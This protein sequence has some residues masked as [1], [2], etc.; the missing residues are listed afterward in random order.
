MYKILSINPG[1][2]STKLGYFEDDE[3]IIIKNIHHNSEELLK[4]DKV[5]DQLDFRTEEVEKFL[6]ENNI[7]INE[8]DGVG[9]RGGVLPRHTTGTFEVTDKICEFSTNSPLQ[10]PVNLAVLIAKKIADKAGV[11]AYI[12]DGESSLEMLPENMLSGLPELPRKN[13]CHVLNQKAIAR[14]HA[15]TTGADYFKSN[16]IV[17]H[18][19][20]G[21]SVGAHKNGVMIDATDAISEGPFTPERTGSLPTRL[22]ADLIYSGK[23]NHTEMKKLI[24]GKGGFVAYLGTNDAREVE[25][26]ME[27]GDQEAIIVMKG[28]INQIAKEVA[29]MTSH[30]EELDAILFTGG[31]SNSEH[32]VSELKKKL[33]KY[34]EIFIYQKE[35]EMESLSEGVTRIL[36]GEEDLITVDL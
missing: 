8:L 7:N 17:L 36:R 14:F 10:H 26:R 11:K 9:A 32:I 34:A 35:R 29:A 21:I 6:V 1:S 2:T 4:F 33:S 16:Y 15:K 28:M 13:Y 30:F 25:K 31:L 12:T 18:M 23:Y 5:I 24:Q 20:G 22:L 19:G 27:E 3:A